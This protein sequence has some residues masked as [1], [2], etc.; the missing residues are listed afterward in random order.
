M[1]G[2]GKDS[3]KGFKRGEQGVRGGKG[4]VPRGNRNNDDQDMRAYR[5][6]KPA[7]VGGLNRESDGIFN[8]DFAYSDNTYSDVGFSDNTSQQGIHVPINTSRAKKTAGKKKAA[9]KKAAP[10]KAAAKA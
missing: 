6:E 9:P 8:Q 4:K 1:N 7:R 10:K 3:E 2:G 5:H